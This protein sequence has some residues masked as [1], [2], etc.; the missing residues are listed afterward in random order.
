M[1]AAE[2]T[3]LLTGGTGSFGSAFVNLMLAEHPE[4]TIRI[5]SRDELKQ[6]EMAERLGERSQLRYFL[7]DVRDPARL[8]RAMEGADIVVHAAAMK[9]VPLCE[10]NPFEAIQTNV[11]G[12]QNVV[13]A[14]ID[15]GVRRVVG[16]SSDKAVNPVNLYGATKLCA[17]KIL[18]QGNAYVG[19]RATRFSCVRY[20]NVAGSRGSVIPLFKRQAALG[21]LTLTDLRM[22]RF[23]ITLHQAVDLVLFALE[24]ATGGEILVPK[25]PSTRLV[26]L[27]DAIGPDIPRDIV[28]IRPGEK[29]HELLLTSDES[30]HAIDVGRHFIIT[31]E[32]PWWSTETAWPDGKPLEDG[33][34]YSSE[35]NEQW[36]DVDQIR[37]L[38]DG[39]L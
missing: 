7:G 6:Y 21:H 25:I 2:S 14:A 18:V 36:L 26:E 11:V 33:F 1:A 29:L 15:T 24:K 4:V 17:E 9:H 8:S 13:N 3:I 16:L 19:R 22:T 28:G 12:T 20:G 39:E 38:V 37:M 27:A 5:F 34:V 10:Y 30:R 32:H 31:P 23:W 35:T